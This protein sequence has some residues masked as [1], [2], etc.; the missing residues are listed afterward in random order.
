MS[1]AAV[2]FQARAF[3]AQPKTVGKIPLNCGI[4][5]RAADVAGMSC[6]CGPI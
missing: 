6:F 3:A 4:P 1:V 2:M 5:S